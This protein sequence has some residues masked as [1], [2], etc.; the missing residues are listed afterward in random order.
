MADTFLSSMHLRQVAQGPEAWSEEV[1]PAADGDES[2]EPLDLLADRP[3]GDGEIEGAVLGAAER[4]ALVP[5]V[6]EAGIVHP[7]VHGELELADQA[8][9]SEKRSDPPLHAL[10]GRPLGERRSVGPS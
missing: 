8:R 6:L 7:H 3:G 1:R 2:G 9:T 4:V 5:Q 10:L